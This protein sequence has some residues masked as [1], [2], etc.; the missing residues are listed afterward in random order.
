MITAKRQLPAIC[1]TLLCSMSAALATES[2]GSTY[3]GGAENYM[4]GAVP[5]PVSTP[6]L[7]QRLPGRHFA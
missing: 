1:M 2:G 5:R 6:D 3:N 4:A 7:W